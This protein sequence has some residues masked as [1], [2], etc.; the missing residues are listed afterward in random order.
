MKKLAR[1][2]KGTTLL[3]ERKEGRTACHRKET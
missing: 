2:K 1:E 3:G